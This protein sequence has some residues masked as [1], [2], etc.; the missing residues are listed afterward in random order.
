[1]ASWNETPQHAL[2]CGLVG[3][4]IILCTKRLRVRSPVR[5]HIGGNGLMFLTLMSLLPPSSLSKPIKTY[6]QVRIK[7]KKRPHSTS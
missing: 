7:K 4:G 6:P 2:A 5:A 1:M 3:W